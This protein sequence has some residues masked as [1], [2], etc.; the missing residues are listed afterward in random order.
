MV[1]ELMTI[2]QFKDGDRKFFT[3]DGKIVEETSSQQDSDAMK[4]A[5][6][7]HSLSGEMM[8]A[9]YSKNVNPFGECEGKI[10]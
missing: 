9:L 6:E 4:V 3:I 2:K 1:E 5:L 7:L 10:Q 8:K